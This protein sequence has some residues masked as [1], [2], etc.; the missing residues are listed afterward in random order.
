MAFKEMVPANVAE[1]Q[2]SIDELVKNKVHVSSIKVDDGFILIDLSGKANFFGHSDMKIPL[3]KERV[4]DAR[5]LVAALERAVSNGQPPPARQ[6]AD[7]F[8]M[9]KH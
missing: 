5:E 8:D 2:A 1:L 9:I 7:L 3:K 4:G 6:V